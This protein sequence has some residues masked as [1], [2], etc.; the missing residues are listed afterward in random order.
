MLFD[1]VKVG[2]YTLANRIVMAPMTRSRAGAGFVPQEIAAKYYAQRASAG[3]IVT[4]ATQVSPQGIG[5]VHTPGIYTEA[6][7][8]G[9]K[10]VTDAVH[11]AGGRIFLQLWH[12]GRISNRTLQEKIA[13]PVAP[14]AIAPKGESMTIDYKMTPYETPRALETGEIAGIVADFRKGAENAKAAGFDGVELHGA[15]GYLIDQ[16]LRDGTN[17][18]TDQYGGS[19]ENRARFLVEVTEAVA[20]VWGGERVGV[21]LSPNA[22]FNDMHDSDPRAIFGHAAKALERFNLAYLHVTRAGPGDDVPGGPIDADFFR[23]LFRNTIIS[24]AGYGSKEEAEAQLKSGNADAIAFATLF[25]SNPDLP[26]R[27]K[28]N[29]PLASADRATFYGGDAKGYIDYPSLEAAV[30]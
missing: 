3:L 10:K 1:P 7:V 28:Q 9:W 29:A 26:A 13:L 8:E 24:A 27:F 14:S 6:Q 15:N 21:R 11:K 12:V 17:R 4:E 25:I 30:A 18:R 19:V 2:P 22:A 23:P 16:F 5:Y 20:G